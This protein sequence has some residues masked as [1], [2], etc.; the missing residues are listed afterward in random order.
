MPYVFMISLLIV[1][2]MG[3]LVVAGWGLMSNIGLSMMV[4]LVG[5]FLGLQWGGMF[6]RGL[7]R[8]WLLFRDSIGLGLAICHL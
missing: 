1:L 5:S 8:L 6:G 7:V 4:A 3:V 2:M